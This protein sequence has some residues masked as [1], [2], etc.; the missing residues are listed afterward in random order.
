MLLS[1]KN[2]SFLPYLIFISISKLG[3]TPNSLLHFP[4]DHKLFG[5]RIG[6]IAHRQ[7]PSKPL[8]LPFERR[9]GVCNAF[10]NQITLKFSERGKQVEKKGIVR[11]RPICGAVTMM[12]SIPRSRISFSSRTLSTTVLERRSSR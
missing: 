9:P 6:I 7:C 3:P 12:R 1:L 5:M 10:S 11:S 4:I 2:G 8:A